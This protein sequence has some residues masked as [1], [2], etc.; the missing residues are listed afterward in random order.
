MCLWRFYIKQVIIVVDFWEF[1]HALYTQCIGSYSKCKYSD[2]K[3][4]QRQKEL[5]QSKKN[6]PENEKNSIIKRIDTL[7]LIMCSSKYVS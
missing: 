7:E 1:S 4:C 6:R 3:K 2:K 5:L